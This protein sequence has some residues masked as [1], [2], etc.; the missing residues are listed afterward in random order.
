MGW[1]QDFGDWVGD[2]AGAVAGTV[3]M[4]GV[5]TAV[6]AAADSNRRG[7]NDVDAQIAANQIP[8]PS[9]LDPNSLPSNQA[10]LDQRLG[11]AGTKASPWLTMATQKQKLDEARLRDQ[12][13]AES[14]GASAGA[15][16]SLAMRGG[17]SGGAA[18]RLA[19]GG[20]QTGM[21]ARNDIS[22]QGMSDRLG[23]GMK[24]FDTQRENVGLWAKMADSETQRKSNLMETNYTEGMRAWAA[25]QAANA[26]LQASKKTGFLGLW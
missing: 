16:S 12:A 25:N 18:E 10:E 17:L 23:L 6:G 9:Q 13:V 2:N 4:P 22:R 11:A 21:M 1:L 20:M 24:D 15:R 26:E 8:R 5:G 3:L 7:N 19:S 14:M